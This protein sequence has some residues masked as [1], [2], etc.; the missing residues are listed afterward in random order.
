MDT[1]TISLP[2][3]AATKFTRSLTRAVTFVEINFLLFILMKFYT[4]LNSFRLCI[5]IS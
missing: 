5:F 2:R 3:L 4:S 1:A